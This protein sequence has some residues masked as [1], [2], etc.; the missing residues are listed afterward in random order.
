[1]NYDNYDLNENSPLDSWIDFAKSLPIKSATKTWKN[2]NLEER[3][4]FARNI[5]VDP[6]CKES[7]LEL[8]EYNLS[9]RRTK[10]E[11]EAMK[12]TLNENWGLY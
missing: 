7:E 8:I 12:Q 6:T 2:M 1:M 9:I 11:L 5:F 3:G 10:E 4:R